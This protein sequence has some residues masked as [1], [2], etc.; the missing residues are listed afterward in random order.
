MKSALAVRASNSG[1]PSHRSGTPRRLRSVQAAARRPVSE[2]GS[3]PVLLVDDSPAFLRAAQQVLQQPDLPFLVH[4][5]ASGGEALAFLQRRPPFEAAPRPDFVILDFR[6][7]DL[8]A[9]AVLARMME[10]EDLRSIPVLVVSQAAWAEDEQAARAAGA[11]DYRVKPS[12]VRTLRDL[13][14]GFWGTVNA[15]QDPT[16]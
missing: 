7:P 1:A 8:N 9:P 10:R 12:R 2:P 13:V 5:V 16:G 14:V 15:N 6:L 11:R 3:V 4:T